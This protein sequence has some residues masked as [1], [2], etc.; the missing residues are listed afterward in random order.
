MRELNPR[1]AQCDLGR[2]GISRPV[3]SI[4]QKEAGIA[5]I[6]TI[7]NEYWTTPVGCD[8]TRDQELAVGLGAATPRAPER[9]KG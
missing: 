8:V 2:G 4:Y 5:P 6:E 9:E 3:V 1:C 7:A